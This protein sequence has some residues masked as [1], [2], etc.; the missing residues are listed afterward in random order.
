[1]VGVVRQ[2]PVR[3]GLLYAGTS[4][5]IWVSFDDGGSWRSLQL[6]LPTTGINDLR[7]HGDDLVVATDGRGIWILDQLAPLRSFAASPAAARMLVPPGRAYRLRGNQNKDTPL[8]PEEP[9]GENP[10]AGAILDYVLPEGIA[11]PVTLELVH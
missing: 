1:W 9:R 11:G 6:N 7:I 3:A 10:P 5:G 8:P 2:D 4:R